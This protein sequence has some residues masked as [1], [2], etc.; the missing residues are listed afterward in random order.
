MKYL[1]RVIQPNEAVRHWGKFHWVIH[2]RAALLL[3]L[4][5][6]GFLAAAFDVISGRGVSPLYLVVGSAGLLL[7]LVALFKS[8]VHQV[9][10]EFAVT[11]KRVILK[12]GLIARKTVEINLGRVE[13]VDV[14][15]SVLGRVLNYGTVS[16]HGAGTHI[17]PLRH[18]ARPSELRNA[19]DAR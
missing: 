14:E 1:E 16:V 4:A 18:M 15:Q 6:A 3:V 11:D 9:T 19:I 13:S 17:R 2:G 5:L 7:G 12:T 8:W 10:T